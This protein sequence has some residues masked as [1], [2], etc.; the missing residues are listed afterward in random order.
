M[1]SA[2]DRATHHRDGGRLGK[3]ARMILE[4]SM[5]DGF[6]TNTYLVADEPGGS[7]VLVDAGGPMGPLFDA[8]ERERPRR[9]PRCC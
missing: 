7:A 2:R 1:P 9:S 3:L 6:L 4:R 5:S 8:L